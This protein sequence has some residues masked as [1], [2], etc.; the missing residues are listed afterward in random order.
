MKFT[1]TIEKALPE[2]SGTS[3]SG[4]AWRKREYVCVYD[5]SNANY[6]KS[7]VFQVMN[8]NIDKLNLQQGCEY[9]LEVDFDSREWNGRYFLQAS[10]WKATPLQA[11]PV[12]QGWPAAYPQ[13][14]AQPQATPAPQGGDDLPF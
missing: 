5:R 9:E 11:Q 4:N 13:P 14:T 7:V 1:G 6:P 8:D 10:C 3:K 12:Q 2:V